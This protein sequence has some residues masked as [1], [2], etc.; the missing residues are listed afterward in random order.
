[1]IQRAAQ[2]FAPKGELHHEKNVISAST[3]VCP[4]ATA[5]YN[6]GC[7]AADF[8]AADFGSLLPT[9]RKSISDVG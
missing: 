6:I 8:L 1:M 5:V 4:P 3:R 2:T 9:G 7:S